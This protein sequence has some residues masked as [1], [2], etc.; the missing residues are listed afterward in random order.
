MTI[1]K[2]RV[3]TIGVSVLLVLA[4][5]IGLFAINLLRPNAET[6]VSNC[7]ET[8]LFND[9]GNHAYDDAFSGD[10]AVWKVFGKYY[11][12]YV[13][14][15]KASWTGGIC[16]IVPRNSR[17]YYASDCGNSNLYFPANGSAFGMAKFYANGRRVYCFDYCTPFNG[18]NLSL[19]STL[20]AAGIPTNIV[21]EQTIMD[22]AKA[23]AV[24]QQNNWAYLK[25]IAPQIAK[26]ATWS[27]SNYGN[28]SSHATKYK[29]GDSIQSSNTITST[30]V[31]NMLKANSTQGNTAREYITQWMV[32]D[33]VNNWYAYR[34]PNPT[35]S[36][37]VVGGS[38]NGKGE[39]GSANSNTIGGCITW[40]NIINIKMMY[41]LARN[42]F[43]KTSSDYMGKWYKEYKMKSGEVKTITGDEATN[44][45]ATYDAAGSA[46]A[47]WAGS[48]SAVK[49]DINRNANTVTLTGLYPAAKYEK[50]SA[51]YTAASQMVYSTRGGR[52][53]GRNGTSGDCSGAQFVADATAMVKRQ[54][55]IVI[56]PTDAYITVHKSSPSG[57]NPEGA[58]YTVYGNSR[59]TDALGT[60]T[61]GS[62]GNA[63]QALKV[64]LQGVAQKDV[65][66]KE[67]G[68]PT[69][70]ISPDWHWVPD[71]NVYKVTLN[72][73]YRQDAPYCV[74][75]TNT[76][77]SNFGY[78]Q[79]FKTVVKTEP[80]S[81][82]VYSPA[83]ATYGI[84]A[85]KG[86]T[87]KLG[88][89]TINADG[90]SEKFKVVWA[91]DQ[92]YKDVW[93]KELTSPPLPNPNTEWEMDETVYNARIV[94]HETSI[95][96]ED[97]PIQL[98]K[99]AD[100]IIEY[101]YLRV[102]K[103][104]QSAYADVVKD[105]SLYA[106]GHAR[107]RVKALTGK[108]A[109]S[110]IG[111]YE[112]HDDGW[113][114]SIRVPVGRYEVEEIV[115]P[116]GHKLDVVNTYELDVHIDTTAETPVIHVFTNRPTADP[117]AIDFDKEWS[118]RK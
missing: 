7:Y 51:E 66:V 21:S 78:V 57:R 80:C 83:G 31:T 41:E 52:Y 88:Q 13:S 28:R 15:S 69:K 3:I 37:R 17:S 100:P 76:V 77:K 81:G 74:N 99:S 117:F 8:P 50:L 59:L 82:N 113:I 39:A 106:V 45:I 53:N 79:V 64:K 35:F 56:E 89:V 112:T 90:Y 116:A 32:W 105:N 27:D 102:R 48:S 38:G 73:T 63:T 104:T 84:F 18:N 1:R 61:I 47:L 25:Q 86:C 110:T 54:M 43:N 46:E 16:N 36:E 55:K 60:L 19:Y 5:V 68:I 40:D 92:N 4:T 103:T 109:G 75:S 98:I 62:N 96:P 85:D 23:V 29:N 14:G 24:L 94:G 97:Q 9:G 87:Q 118:K 34:N 67:T 91:H 65:W 95:K 71:S 114:D 42:E 107:F 20:A 22:V 115:P 108:L 111:E 58:V 2:W 30:E 44:F 101:G 93:V 10:S 49:I 11:N 72:A 33:V 6:P 70:D 12:E 26:T